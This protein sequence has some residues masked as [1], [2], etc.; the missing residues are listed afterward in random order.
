[1][2][3]VPVFPSEEWVDE[4]CERFDAHPQ[5]AE[6]ASALDGVYRFTVEP[7]DELSR[8]VSY[9]V[10][11]APSQRPYATRLQA[12]AERPRLVIAAD[13]RRW[14]QLIRGQLNVGWA[15]AL[16]RVRIAGDLAAVRSE[17]AGAGPL[18]DSLNRV[19]TEWLTA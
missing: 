2:A 16:G 19:E 14:S 8:R 5:A 12:P 18:V 4:F 3:A 15:Y 11:I 9:D 6:T 17:L 13:Y 10:Q 1:V 7:S